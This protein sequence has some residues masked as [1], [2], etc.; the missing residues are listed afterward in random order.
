[1]L[2]AFTSESTAYVL[3]KTKALQ[4][5][6][7]FRHLLMLNK[8]LK[9]ETTLYNATLLWY[10]LHLNK[11]TAAATKNWRLCFASIQEQEHYI[12]HLFDRIS[13]KMLFK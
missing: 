1:M 10:P 2:E 3:Q 5:H 4:A 13:N 6:E 12:K 7:Q 11:G 9:G 8:K